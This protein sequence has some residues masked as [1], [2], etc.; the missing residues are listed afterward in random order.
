MSKTGKFDFERITFKF[1]FSYFIT[2]DF[3]LET[4]TIKHNT[5]KKIKQLAKKTLKL[6]QPFGK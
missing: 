6:N 3:V 5:F 4:N 2:R 1:A